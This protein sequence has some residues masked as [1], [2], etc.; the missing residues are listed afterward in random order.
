LSP[1]SGHDHIDLAAATLGTDQ[2]LAPAE[3]RCFDATSGSNLD[4]VGF[5]LVPAFLT[6]HDQPH[7]GP[8]GHFPDSVKFP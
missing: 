4:G 6:P 7:A 5:D 2:P 3:H 8:A 1:G